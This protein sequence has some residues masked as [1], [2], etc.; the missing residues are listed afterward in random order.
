MRKAIFLC[1]L[2][3]IAITVSAK[4]LFKDDGGSD[5]QRNQFGI[6]IG[7]G[8]MTNVNGGVGFIAGANYM[9]NI[10]RFFSWDV[11]GINYIGQTI[12]NNGLSIN[13]LQ[14]LMGLKARTPYIYEDISGYCG[15]RMGYGY[16]FNI[17]HGGLALEFNAGVDV[18]SNM[19]VGYV[20]NLQ[21][22]NISDLS[23]KYKF[24][25]LKLGYTF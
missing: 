6:N 9:Y 23:T 10:H 14:G 5:L 13:V 3:V 16:D 21:K 4:D 22:V 18:T 17:S 25:G 24:H 2:S 8:K 19:S 11:I 20:F 1:L 7:I 15:L 12:K